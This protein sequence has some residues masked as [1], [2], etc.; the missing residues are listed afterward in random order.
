MEDKDSE[1]IPKRSIFL[2]LLGILSI[3]A[4]FVLILINIFLLTGSSV[5][6]WVLKVP[7]I[8]TITEE[9]L[10]GNYGYFFLKIILHGFCIYAVSLILLMKRRGFFYY[11]GTQIILLLL[12][13]LFL[14]SLGGS[15]LLISSGV[16]SIFSV[17]FIMLFSLYITRMTKNKNP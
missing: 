11:L 2:Y 12:P 6:N 7:V 14:R 5:I 4:N 8:D 9:E 3:L 15:Y 13:F 16:S 1:I 17:F 10:H